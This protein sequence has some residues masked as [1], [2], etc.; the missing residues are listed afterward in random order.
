MTVDLTCRCCNGRGTEWGTKMPGRPSDPC[1]TCA[2]AG[3]LDAHQVAVDVARAHGTRVAVEFTGL[4]DSVVRRLRRE[5]DGYDRGRGRPSRAEME[6]MRPR[7]TCTCP[8]CLDAR[9]A[10][11]R[12]IN[13]IVTGLELDRPAL[14]G[15]WR[16]DAACADA[17]PELFFPG[18][19]VNTSE[20]LAYC[21]RCPVRDR[22][23]DAGL[24]EHHGIWG[25]LSERGRRRVRRIRRA[26]QNAA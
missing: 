4:T 22:C 10:L 6:A 9:A 8:Y 12:K 16:D 13:H 19:G 7:L 3:V 26:K 1:V 23:L 18:R 15:S 21:R 2:G 11:A 5:H 17:D 24:D 14:G 25:G 20:A